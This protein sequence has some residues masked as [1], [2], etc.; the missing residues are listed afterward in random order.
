MSEVNIKVE[1]AGSVYPL[2]IDE[3]D[4]EH[5]KEAV[6]LINNKISEFER[7]YGVRDKKDLLGM[8]MLQLVAQLLGQAKGAEKDLSDLRKLFTDVEE[9]VRNHQRNIN[10][11]GD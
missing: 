1:I 3:K 2:K 5:I 11:L 9:M 4:E 10:A 8:V 7:N 6:R